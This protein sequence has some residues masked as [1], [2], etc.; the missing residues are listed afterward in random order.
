MPPLASR[1]VRIVL[2]TSGALVQ[3]LPT[4]VLADPPGVTA[5]PAPPAPA[6]PTPPN[7]R[8]RRQPQPGRRPRCP[9]PIPPGLPCPMPPEASGH[10]SGV[11]VEGRLDVRVQTPRPPSVRVEGRAQASE[12]RNAGGAP[13]P[14]R[15]REGTQETRGGEE[16]DKERPEGLEHRGDAAPHPPPWHTSTWDPYDLNAEEFT[17]LRPCREG[18]PFGSKLSPRPRCRPRWPASGLAWQLRLGVPGGFGFVWGPSLQVGGLARHFTLGSDFWA[19]P[20]LGVG[21]DARLVTTPSAWTD[22]DG[23]GEQDETSDLDL[24]LIG[25]GLRWRLWTDAVAR[26]GWTLRFDAHYGVPSDG[27]GLHPGLALSGMLERHVGGLEIDGW[28]WELA[29]GVRYTQGLAGLRGWH[30][31]LL[32][33]SIRIGWN[34]FE[35]D[36]FDGDPPRP[37]GIPHF[38]GTLVT[39]PV[40]AGLRVGFPWLDG[41]LEGRVQLEHG[42]QKWRLRPDDDSL[43]VGGAWR[44]LGG[45]RLNVPLFFFGTSA[46]TMAA[47]HIELLGGGS[48]T[49]GGPPGSSFLAPVAQAQAGLELVFSSVRLDVAAGGIRASLETEPRM[50]RWTPYFFFPVLSVEFGDFEGHL[51]TSARRAHRRREAERGRCWH[52]WEHTRSLSADC[53]ELIG[54]DVRLRLAAERR[55]S[56]THRDATARSGALVR[57]SRPAGRLDAEVHLGVGT[58]S[59]PHAGGEAAPALPPTHPPSEF[60]LGVFAHGTIQG[61]AWDAL[62]WGRIA[63]GRARLEFHL[64]PAALPLVNAALRIEARRRGVTLRP[65]QVVWRTDSSIQIKVFVHAR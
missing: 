61:L 16:R 33:G 26:E 54:D 53:E 29:L 3:T 56:A 11:R 12:R 21:L 40:A 36:E 24:W 4:G 49:T 23:D 8:P 14:P 55:A 48:V 45:L 62:P 47:F 27:Y 1:I 5:R 19:T 38:V 34:A 25:G 65:G 35:P 44:L 28:N 60:H 64:P 31:V 9:V 2:L 51:H 15:A 7:D 17:N 50:P 10:R 20:T 46:K 42:Q 57:P 63:A 41:W 59:S 43:F 13:R 52:R 6:R 30:A 58:V 22:E 18:E 39:F 37:E 32:D